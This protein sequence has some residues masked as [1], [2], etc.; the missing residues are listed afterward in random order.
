M[1]SLIFYRRNRKNHL[2][3]VYVC[4][5]VIQKPRISLLFIKFCC[6]IILIVFSS[7]E[8]WYSMEIVSVWRMSVKRI[9]Q[10]RHRHLLCVLCYVIT[11]RIDLAFSGRWFK[12]DDIISGEDKA[13][14]VL[15]RVDRSFNAKAIACQAKNRVATTKESTIINVKCT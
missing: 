15:E 8:N 1:P 2:T 9:A 4:L 14:L 10:L 3:F 6:V 5:T 7:L 13:T 12:D 11:V